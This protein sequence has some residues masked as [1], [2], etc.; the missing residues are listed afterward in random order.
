MIEIAIVVIAYNRQKSLARLLT[1]LEDAYYM[2]NV[3]L[4]ISIDKGDNQSVIDCANKFKWSHGTKIVL[5][6]KSNLG[7]RKHILSCGDLLNQY[8][9][10]IV[11]EDDLVVSKYYYD[12]ALKTVEKYKDDERI[13]GISLYGFNI[14]YHN[15]LPFI[16]M[17]SSA[18]VYFMQNAQSWGE[19]WMKKQWMS[20]IEWYQMHDEDFSYSPHLPKSICSWKKSSWLK[21][22]TKYCIENNKYFVYPY[23]SYSSNVGES[24]THASFSSPLFIVPLRDIPLDNFNLLDFDDSNVFYDSFFENTMLEK[25]IQKDVDSNSI[26]IDLYGFKGNQENKRYWL[27]TTLANYKV[28]KSYGLC[29]SPIECNVINNMEGSGIFLYDTS[30]SLKSQITSDRRRTF[31]YMNKYD[32]A[33]VHNSILNFGVVSYLKMM[34]KIILSKF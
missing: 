12:Y 27:T 33:H 2:R 26:C 24:G 8:D 16:P 7:L 22:H 10:I 9:A 17:M 31:Y 6:Q 14:N 32:I 30:I 21:Y 25:I 5:E 11:L 19:I 15:E 34:V 20:F 18:D 1:T 28:I 13:A 3:P 4:Y 23:I 29:Y